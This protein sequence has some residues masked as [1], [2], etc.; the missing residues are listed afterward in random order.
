MDDDEDNYQVNGT[1][2]QHQYHNPNSYN[3]GDDND[4]DDENG[5]NGTATAA[6]PQ[7][8]ATTERL[9]V[10]SYGAIDVSTVED[11][12]WLIRIPQAVFDV[13]DKAD[14]G[15]ELGNL[16][17][18][19]GGPAVAAGGGAVLPSM[20]VELNEETVRQQLIQNLNKGS[21]QKKAATQ[22]AEPVKM[23]PLQ[24]TLQAM[25]KKCPVMHPF[26]RNPNTGRVQLLGTVSRTANL[27]VE[28][29]DSNYR[30]MLKNRLVS[31]MTVNKFVKPVE[32][33]DS[34]LA[35][36][37]QQQQAASRKGS[38]LPGTTRK[39]SFGDAVYQYGKRKLEAIQEAN[40]AANNPTYSMNNKKKARH[41]FASDQPLR[42]VLFELFQ[43]QQYWTIKDLKTAAIQGGYGSN[44]S[45]AGGETSSSIS[46]KRM[47][48]EIR[49]MLR[50]EIGEYH[51]SGDH[52]NKWEL[53]K[54]FQQYSSNTMGGT[55]GGNN[56]NNNASTNMSSMNSNAKS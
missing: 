52:K 27:Q 33:T 34:V 23:I 1:T 15:T 8:E 53:R 3:E 39:N 17:F 38:I 49:E 18:T 20:S 14:E 2:Y 31:T 42:S 6:A 10:H 55:N 41:Q 46:I 37:R 13:W 19:K 36:Q 43:Q 47:D 11:E 29:N 4:E 7:S 44:S 12:C 54:E 28:R 5:G 25:T 40:I 26:V 56:N 30:T 50:D 32:T 45:T 21:K 51:R 24:Y 16:V 35:K 22:P 9:T 48:G